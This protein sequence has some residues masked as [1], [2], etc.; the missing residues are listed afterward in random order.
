FEK[1]LPDPAGTQRPVV[2][3]L[4][5]GRD[6]IGSTFLGVLRRYADTVK[7]TGG[8]VILTGVDDQVRHQLARTGMLAYLGEENVFSATP[9]L[10]EAMNQAVAAAQAWLDD[11]K[12]G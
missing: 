5:R 8:K 2:I 10:G 4:M 9:Q 3:L 7:G 12:T 6:E 1:L 11:G